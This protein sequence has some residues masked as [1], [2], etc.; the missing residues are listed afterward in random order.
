MHLPHSRRGWHNITLLY[1]SD[2]SNEICNKLK[3]TQ[4]SKTYSFSSYFVFSSS[5]Y[6]NEHY[7][8][9]TFLHSKKNSYASHAFVLAF[10]FLIPNC[11]CPFVRP[12]CRPPSVRPSVLM[13][14]CGNLIS[15]RSIDLKIGLN[16]GY[17]VVH[18]QNA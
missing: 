14:F 5:F 6:S 2:Y 15:N 4:T 1:S 11:L 12:S 17:G 7:F 3:A 9:S 10:F 16:V 13:S 18:V 8:Q